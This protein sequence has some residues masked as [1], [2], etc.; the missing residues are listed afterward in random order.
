[1]EKNHKFLWLLDFL[2]A[3]IA[4][5][6]TMENF[7]EINKRIYPSLLETRPK[8]S[9]DVDFTSKYKTAL[10]STFLAGKFH[11]SILHKFS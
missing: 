3:V 9:K 11:I 4:P 10:L 5:F 1:M 6:F 8:R 2:Y 7:L